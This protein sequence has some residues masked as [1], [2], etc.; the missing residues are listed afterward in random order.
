MTTGPNV[1]LVD[2][3][4]MEKRPQSYH[5]V[6]KLGA[7]EEAFPT[8]GENIGILRL[9]NLLIVDTLAGVY[10]N[11]AFYESVLRSPSLPKVILLVSDCYEDPS[12]PQMGSKVS[13]SISL[14]KI[15]EDRSSDVR[16]ILMTS[17]TGTFWAPESVSPEGV[18]MWSQD[19]DGAAT[20]GVIV[21]SLRLGEIFEE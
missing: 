17:R 21:E 14:P 8:N 19:P 2:L 6:L 10:K 15:F 12:G 4:S 5:E 13:P 3:A 11:Q 18:A 1:L 7:S 16:V 9:K 20:L